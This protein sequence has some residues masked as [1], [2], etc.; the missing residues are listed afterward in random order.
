[1][2]S[3]YVTDRLPS[4][5]SSQ[6]N[7]PFQIS[8]VIEFPTAHIIDSSLISSLCCVSLFYPQSLFRRSQWPRRLRRDSAAA[9]LLELRVRIPS[10]GLEVSL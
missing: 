3:Q 6:V 1:M 10:R 8:Y 9:R 7:P 4:R 2:K 5:N